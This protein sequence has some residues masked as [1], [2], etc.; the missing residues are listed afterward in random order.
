MSIGGQLVICDTGKYLVRWE[1][2]LSYLV[3]WFKKSTDGAE[4]LI[5][6]QCLS[7]Y[8]AFT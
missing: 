5:R 2:Y 6:F 1:K 8:Y 3:R 7:K 4:E